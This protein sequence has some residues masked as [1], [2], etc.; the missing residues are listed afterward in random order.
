MRTHHPCSRRA[1]GLARRRRSRNDG[2]PTGHGARTD[3]GAR[4]GRGA[5]AGHGGAGE[6]RGHGVAR[7]R[8]LLANAA[9]P[10]DAGPV[11]NLDYRTLSPGADGGIERWVE[12][13]RLLGGARGRCNLSPGRRARRRLQLDLEL[14]P[15]LRR[16]VRCRGN[17]T[18]LGTA[19]A[20]R[21]T[22]SAATG[23]AATV[24]A[25]TVSAA[26]SRRLPESMSL[27]E[28]VGGLELPGA[29]AP[30]HRSERRRS[31]A[32]T[33]DADVLAPGSALA[34]PGGAGLA[35]LSLTAAGVAA[36]DTRYLESRRRVRP[37]AG[38]RPCD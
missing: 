19:P 31:R 21:G 2:A 26:F 29:E 9:S 20:C 3:H 14:E 25:R 13:P 15:G 23:P 34:P 33:D 17:G 28:A 38:P 12:M 4:T 8:R 30:T 11:L 10:D 37:R 6:G 5:R 16:R 35:E 36:P 18:G 1:T 27:A 7:P 24:P 32:A 22:C